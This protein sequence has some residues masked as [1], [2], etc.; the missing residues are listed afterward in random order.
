MFMITIE[1]QTVWMGL[2]FTLLVTLFGLIWGRKKLGQQPVLAF[3]FVACAV[4]LLLYAG[5]GLYWSG[6]PE[7]SE[8]GPI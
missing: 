2:P 3:F 4:A 6:F 5:W 1:G 7:F 8:A